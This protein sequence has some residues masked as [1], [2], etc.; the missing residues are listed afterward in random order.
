MNSLLAILFTPSY[1]PARRFSVLAFFVS[2]V[3]LLLSGCSF[4]DDTGE[5][6][7]PAE[8]TQQTARVIKVKDGD[9]IILRFANSI[10]KEARLFGIDAPEYNQAFGHDAKAILSK[11]V[12][13]KSVL[14]ESRGQDRYQREIV[15]LKIDNQKT[16]IN[17]QM[18]ERGAAWV[19][20]KYQN[21]KTW[22]NSQIK[23]QKNSL[24]LWA[25]SAA[26]APWDWRENSKKHKK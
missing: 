21:D 20:S 8:N 4:D 3:V 19:Y 9:S 13:K 18:I 22:Q 1:K 11:L 23:A 25:N 16:S 6:Q 24:G 12:Y 5:N 17:Q 10:E 26:I 15:I 14:V 7:S 2:I